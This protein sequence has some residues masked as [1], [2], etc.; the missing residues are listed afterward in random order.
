MKKIKLGTPVRVDWTDAVGN[1]DEALDI[2]KVMNHSLIHLR[3]Y[4]VLMVD[5][6][7]RVTIVSHV[8]I[9]EGN[10]IFKGTLA[11]PKSWVIKTVA[12]KEA[13]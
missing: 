5:N 9:D 7:E 4:G 11:I 8:G 13:K 12:L 3:S 2:S 1:D 6:A 10:P